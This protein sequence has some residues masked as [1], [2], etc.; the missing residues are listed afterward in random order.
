MKP[1][2]SE[3]TI[4]VILVILII[5]KMLNLWKDSNVQYSHS[6]NSKSNLKLFKN[7]EYELSTF[8]HDCHIYL[9]F[10]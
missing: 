1:C 9:R 7:L 4:F 10:P 8:T 5:D 6:D 2:S 3:R